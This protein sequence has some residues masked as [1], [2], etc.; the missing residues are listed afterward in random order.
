MQDGVRIGIDIVEVQRVQ[1][2]MAA[3]PAAELELFSARELRQVAESRNRVDRPSARFAAK[4]AVLKAM[5]T[6]MARGMTWLDIETV[7][8]PT[9]RPTLALHGAVA[10]Y[11]QHLGLGAGTSR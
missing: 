3:H 8:T 9:G 4:E 10:T 2:M 1:A 7:T 6:G 11:A 5:G